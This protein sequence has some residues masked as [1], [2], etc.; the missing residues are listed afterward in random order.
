MTAFDGLRMLDLARIGPGPYCSMLLGDM[1]VDV[2]RIEPPRDERRR[3]PAADEAGDDEVTRARRQANDAMGRNKRSMVLNLR[4]A[5]GRAIVHRLAE[6]ADVFL[7]GFR[8]GVVDRLDVG[9]ER[10]SAINPRVVYCSISGYGQDGPYRELVGHDINYIAMAGMLGLVGRPGQRPA[11]PSN[12][13]ADYAGG[14]LMAAFAIASA[15]YARERSDHGQYIDLAMSDGVLYLLAKYA[16]VLLGEPAPEA[17]RERNTGLFP[18]YEVYQC[19]DGKWIALGSL[20]PHFWANL[21]HAVGREDFIELLPELLDDPDAFPEVRE[22]FERTFRQKTRDE[23]FAELRSIELC[24]A[25]VYALDEAFADPHNAGR[26]VVE[27]DDPVAGPVPTLGIGP[28]L[29]GTPGSIRRPAP[30]LGEHGDEVLAELGY[31]P[32]AIADLRARG[33]LG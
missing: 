21:C 12:I 15:L 27:V 9:Y 11:I 16:H 17:G 24:V 2:L 4:E 23:W 25:P 20:E 28:K 19:A 13:V 31:D 3:Q 8:P 32:D 14:G 1:G 29:S 7:E 5:E 18:H 10:I 6:T 33:V 22:H 26:M 30:R